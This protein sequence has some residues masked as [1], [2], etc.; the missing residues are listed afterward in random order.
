[1]VC[2]FILI[3]IS[4]QAMQLR[5]DDFDCDAHVSRRIANDIKARSTRTSRKDAPQKF[6]ENRSVKKEEY[7]NYYFVVFIYG[8][9]YCLSNQFKILLPIRLIS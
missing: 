5:A 4:S 3:E 9:N 6:D 7:A 1:M 2:F 8:F